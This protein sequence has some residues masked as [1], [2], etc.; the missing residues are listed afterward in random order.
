M[1]SPVYEW[2]AFFL[3]VV[4]LLPALD[5]WPVAWRPGPYTWAW[6]LSLLAVVVLLVGW[7]RV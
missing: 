5:G 6:L 7:S 1:I 4:V 3:C 2:F